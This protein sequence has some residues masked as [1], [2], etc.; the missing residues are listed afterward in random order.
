M[1][2]INLEHAI[3]TLLNKVEP[4]KVIEEKSILESLGFILGE[5]IYSKLDNPPFNRSPLDGFT[6]NHADSIASSKEN[7]TI[8]KVKSDIFAGEYCDDNINKNE[9]FRIMTGA[10]IPNG[11]DCVIKQEE[12]EFDE[13]TKILKISR[14][15]KKYEN[16]CFAGEDLKSGVLVVK[17][18]ELITYNHI[19]IF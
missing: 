19:G 6:F 17:A 12:V 9:A 15:L 18:G 4:L 8:F 10:P 1:E 14:E 13:I 5:D 7:Q 11:C 16:F 2:G 3:E